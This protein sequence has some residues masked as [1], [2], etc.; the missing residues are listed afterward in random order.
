MPRQLKATVF[1]LCFLSTGTTAPPPF[2]MCDGAVLYHRVLDDV[3][4]MLHEKVR[5]GTPEPWVK[6]D[7]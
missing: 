7:K 3:A 4:K 2:V 6:G 1:P 5:K